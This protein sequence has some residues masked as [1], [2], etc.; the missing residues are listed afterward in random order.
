LKIPDAESVFSTTRNYLRKQQTIRKK[1]DDMQVS[2]VADE[3][4]GVHSGE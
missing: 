3:Q 1:S 2:I 4:N